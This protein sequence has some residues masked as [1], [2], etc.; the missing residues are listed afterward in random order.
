[1]KVSYSVGIY[2]DDG[3]K[4]DNRILLFIEGSPLIIAIPTLTELEGFHQNI[5][6]IIDEIKTGH[7]INEVQR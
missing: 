4:Y 1:M 5:G 2:D 7:W 3:D 6:K